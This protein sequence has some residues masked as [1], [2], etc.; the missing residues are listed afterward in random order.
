MLAG[1]AKKNAKFYIINANKLAME[2]HMGRHTNTILQSAFFKLNPQIMPFEKSLELMKDSARHTY[3]RKGEDVVNA[4]IAAIDAGSTGLVEVAVKPEWADLTYDK[5][6]ITKTGDEYFDNNLQ[7]INAL[8][9]YDMPVSSFMKYGVLDGS[10]PENVAF[11][12]KRNIAA[13][14]PAWDSAKCVECGKCAFACLRRLRRMYHS[15]PGK[16]SHSSGSQHSAQP[17]QGR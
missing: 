13:Q 8:E 9:G 11:R 17:G 7:R 6:L 10:I 16:G 5:S 1:L 12:E 15:L 14:V 2:C 4:N 3:A